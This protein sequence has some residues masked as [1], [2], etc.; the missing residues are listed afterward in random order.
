[1]QQVIIVGVITLA[2]CVVPAGAA[3]TVDGTRD[4]AYG[5]ATAVQTVQ[6]GFGDANPNGGSELDAAYTRIEGGTLYL[7]LTGNLENNFNKLNIFIDSQVGGQNVLQNDTS[8]GG[9]NPVNEGWAGKYAG[10][11]FD[12]GFA[13][14][15]MLILRNGNFGGDRFDIDFATIGGGAAAFETGS[16]VFGGALTGA[17]ANALPGSG[18]GVAHDRSNTAGVTGGS[19]AADPTAAQAVTTGI[20]LAIP[21]SAIGSPAGAFSISAMINGSNHD[22]LS[23]QFLGGLTPPQ[24][25]V[26]GDGSGGFNGT[27]GQINLNNFPGNQYFTVVPEPSTLVVFGVAL[28]GLAAARRRPIQPSNKPIPMAFS[29]AGSAARGGQRRSVSP[30]ARVVAA[31]PSCA[32]FSPRDYLGVKS[33]RLIGA[34]GPPGWGL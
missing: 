30:R 18:I 11:T 6:T 14:D 16:D 3:P 9:N 15:Y 17:N 24:G 22:Y 5:S 26:G 23:N 10:F 2:L 21:L 13:A 33:L 4:G 8:N 28:G 27:V 32:P 19:G 1:M 31:F 34:S 7:M 12:A 20:E 29:P 25:N